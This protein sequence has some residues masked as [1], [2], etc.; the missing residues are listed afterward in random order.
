VLPEGH[1]FVVQEGTRV[2]AATTAADPPSGLVFYD[3][4]ACLSSLAADK[5]GSDAKK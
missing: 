1:V 5:A 4:R 3:L 2:I